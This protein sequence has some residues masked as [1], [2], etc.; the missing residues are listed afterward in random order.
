[1][2]LR[3][4]LALVASASLALPLFQDRK[5][6]SGPV[7]GKQ[8]PTIRLN[9]EKGLAVSL[10]GEADHWTVLAFYPMAATPG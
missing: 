9:D 3:L 2:R 5:E 6:P 7:V 10:G 8:T 4:P 1:M